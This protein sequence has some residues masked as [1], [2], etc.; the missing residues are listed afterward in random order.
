MELGDALGCQMMGEKWFNAL[1]ARNDT[2]GTVYVCHIA[3]KQDTV[4]CVYMYRY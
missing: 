2:I 1:P 3:M 4:I